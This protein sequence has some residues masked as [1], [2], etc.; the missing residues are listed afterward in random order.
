MC[1]NQEKVIAAINHQ[2]DALTNTIK[3]Q[4][5]TLPKWVDEYLYQPSG[6]TLTVKPQSR[7]VEKI[8]SICCYCQNGSA[9]LILGDRTL[10]LSQGLTIM[11]NLGFL[12]K[13]DDKR[14]LNQATAGILWLELFGEEMGDQGL[15]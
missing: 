6:T 8:T 3:K 5:R 15:F 14:T 4:L 9:Y 10:P 7:N 11:E 13:P 12:L 1:D 2:T